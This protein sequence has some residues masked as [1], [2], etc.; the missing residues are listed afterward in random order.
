[1]PGEALRGIF[2]KGNRMAKRNHKSH[3]DLIGDCSNGDI[4]R[5]SETR[6][7]LSIRLGTWGWACREV[8]S[9]DSPLDV[10]YETSDSHFEF[11]DDHRIDERTFDNATRVKI[12][13]REFDPLNRRG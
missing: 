5:I 11:G 9:G 3:A 4:V 7:V 12:H 8:L 10:E 1:M 13:D 2:S 6:Y